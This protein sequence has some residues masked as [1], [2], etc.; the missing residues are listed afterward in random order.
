VQVL[1]VVRFKKMNVSQ[2]GTPCVCTHGRYTYILYMYV[3]NMEM[4]INNKYQ[5]IIQIN[6][7]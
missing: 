4:K 7:F 6:L 1:Q 5:Y 3:V 2:E